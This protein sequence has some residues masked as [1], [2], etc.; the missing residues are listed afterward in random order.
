MLGDLEVAYRQI[1]PNIEPFTVNNPFCSSEPQQDTTFT[2]LFL[3]RCL[4]QLANA[5]SIIVMWALKPSILDLV[6]VMMK[7]YDLVLAEK[8]PHLQY[9]LLYLLYSH[10][11]CYNHFISN[12]SLVTSKQ[13]LPNLL[14]R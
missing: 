6:G 11:K 9:C 8:K 14:N 7:P 13:E 10:C 2:V 1:V 3:L 12:S 4:S 5:S